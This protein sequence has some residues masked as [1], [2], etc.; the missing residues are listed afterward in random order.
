MVDFPTEGLDLAPYMVA[1]GVGVAADSDRRHGE[2]ETAAAVTSSSTTAQ[3]VGLADDG[4]AMMVD[5]S[6]SGS[7]S[8]NSSSS[9][10]STIYDLFAVSEHIGGLGGGH[11]TAKARNPRNKAW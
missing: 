10:S 4:A 7:S 11:Y 2:D 3:T 1:P 5:A 8:G 9:P 6:S